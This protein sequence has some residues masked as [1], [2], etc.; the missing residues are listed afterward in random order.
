MVPI[1]SEL[2]ESHAIFNVFLRYTLLHTH[3]HGR[4]EGKKLA[5][6]LKAILSCVAETGSHG[7]NEPWTIG[8]N[9]SSGC[10]RLTNDDIIDLYNRPQSVQR[11]SFWLRRITLPAPRELLLRSSAR[12]C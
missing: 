6:P 5:G 2:I 12:S 1:M 7:T 11:F 10:I 8:Q 3:C 4:L 9:V